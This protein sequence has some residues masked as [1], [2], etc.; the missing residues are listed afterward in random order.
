M[1]INGSILRAQAYK[2]GMRMKEV[3]AK[4][5]I[6]AASLS[7]IANGKSCRKETALRI[8]DALSISLNALVEGGKTYEE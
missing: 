3:A 1:F 4:A 5:S 2:K 6:S 8:A 7:C